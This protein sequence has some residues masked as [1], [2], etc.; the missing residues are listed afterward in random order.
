VQ[1]YPWTND[2][3][4]LRWFLALSIPHIYCL[5][6]TSRSE[7]EGILILVIFCELGGGVANEFVMTQIVVPGNIKFAPI[8]RK[9]TRMVSQQ[10]R[11]HRF[12]SP[13]HTQTSVEAT[14]VATS[15]VLVSNRMLTGLLFLYTTF[16]LHLG[17]KEVRFINFQFLSTISHPDADTATNLRGKI[18]M[19]VG[20]SVSSRFVFLNSK[21]LKFVH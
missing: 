16:S 3:V 12:L 14:A 5:Q 11:Y 10:K 13:P 6:A 9:R 4:V 19:M 2:T 17:W 15:D 7:G 1:S 20:R 21:K 8:F 18:S